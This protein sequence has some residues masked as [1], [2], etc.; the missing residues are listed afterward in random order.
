MVEVVVRSGIPVVEC[1][2]VI[3]RSVC[4]VVLRGSE[5]EKRSK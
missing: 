3:E 5:K 2:G 1:E 4:C